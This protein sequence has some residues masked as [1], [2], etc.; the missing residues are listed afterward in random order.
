MQVIITGSNKGPVV[1]IA[2]WIGITM[3]AINVFTRLGL[4][5]FGL[6]E[7]LPDDTLVVATLVSN[8]TLSACALG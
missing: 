2:A 3:I 1:N 7:W 8:Q 6:R 5:C 4:K